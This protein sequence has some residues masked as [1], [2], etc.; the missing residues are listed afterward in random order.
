MGRSAFPCFHGR[1]GLSGVSSGVGFWKKA[2]S[3]CII[4]LN[5]TRL[6]IVRLFWHFSFRHQSKSCATVVFMAATLFL[7]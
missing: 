7:S 5:R 3:V 6:P 4:E 1:R 2:Q